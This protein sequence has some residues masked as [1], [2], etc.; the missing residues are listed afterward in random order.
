MNDLPNNYPTGLSNKEINNIIDELS[1]NIMPQS[2][3]HVTSG[4]G[5]AK[6]VF[7]GKLQLGLNEL[8]NR[9]TRKIMMITVI[10]SLL[11]LVIST[12]TIIYTAQINSSSKILY[13]KVLYINTNILNKLD[14]INNSV[15]QL[16]SLH[17]KLVVDENIIEVN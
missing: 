15:S 2:R 10:V 11:S 13:E 8:R 16:D 14:S 17:F 5:S 4:T 12:L 7:L 6:L 1:K 3:V 9:Q